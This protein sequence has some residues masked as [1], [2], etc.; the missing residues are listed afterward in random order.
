MSWYDIRQYAYALS[1]PA[2]IMF[3]SVRTAYVS[4]GQVMDWDLGEMAEAAQEKAE[5]PQRVLNFFQ[6]PAVKK[7]R[8][9][10]PGF[11]RET[12]KSTLPP[13][14]VW[15][16]DEFGILQPVE[17]W[18]GSSRFIP[19]VEKWTPGVSTKVHPHGHPALDMGCREGEKILA[20][21]DGYV[22]YSRLNPTTERYGKGS[23]GNYNNTGKGYGYEVR[24]AHGTVNG[25]LMESGY[26]H[27][28]AMPIVKQGDWVKAGDVLG[29]CG[30]TGYSV[31]R[32]G[33]WHLHFNLWQDG[34][35]IDPYPY[36]RRPAE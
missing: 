13:L 21:A 5:L 20:G 17:V 3:L 35:R 27:M 22:V 4:D 12:K 32:N 30:R 2:L 11:H 23:Q 14:P 36:L 18:H 34:E 26:H 8:S 9:H 25:H 16:P 29:D 6:R 33:G 10:I 15:N 7:A 28:N 1:V 31:G 19:Y 24:L